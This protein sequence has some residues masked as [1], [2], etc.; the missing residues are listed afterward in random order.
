MAGLG[1][2]LAGAGAG[3]GAPAWAGPAPARARARAGA[4][5][6]TPLVVYFL[7]V[8]GGVLFFGR[9]EKT[10]LTKRLLVY[11]NRNKRLVKLRCSS[12]KQALDKKQRKESQGKKAQERNQ[13]KENQGK[14]GKDRK[15]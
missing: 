5:A 3:A 12:E 7:V 15:L 14:K 8:K 2:G 4:G 13:R 1:L 9:Q 10:L 11:D 6:H